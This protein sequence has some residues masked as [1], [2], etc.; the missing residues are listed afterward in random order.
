M[1]WETIVSKI[2]VAAMRYKPLNRPTPANLDP[3]LPCPVCER[4]RTHWRRI[5][6]NVEMYRCM[7][8]GNIQTYK[9]KEMAEATE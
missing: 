1:D 8:C 6:G 5:M 9:I 4:K 2:G 7:V 3:R